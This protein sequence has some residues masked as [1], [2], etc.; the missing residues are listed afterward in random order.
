MD[1]RPGSLSDTRSNAADDQHTEHRAREI[2]AE[3][4]RTR[5]DL[6]ETV[7]AIQEKLRPANVVASAASATTEKVKDMASSATETAEEWWEASGGS[8]LVDRVR[9]NPVPAVLAGVGLA[10]LAFGNGNGGTARRY[11]SPELTSERGREAHRRSMASRGAASGQGMANARKMISSNG[12]RVE[13][14]I[15]EY[16]LAVAA[17][18]AILGV[19]LGLA[20]PETE[21]ENEL[22]G[23][24]RDTAL[25][26]AQEV[27]TGAVDRAKEAAAD[28]VTRSALGD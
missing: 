27:A 9:N 17:A 12:K 16:P 21:R 15:R 25:Q 3:I 10:W 28:V 18:A 8:S 23:E 19:S 20:V 24:A 22:M 5:E 1:D 4:E 6:S 2:R 11:Q 7:D 26:R 14:M 13:S